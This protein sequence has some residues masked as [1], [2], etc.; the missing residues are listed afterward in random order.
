MRCGQDEEECAQRDEEE[1]EWG[2]AGVECC[3]CHDIIREKG[4]EGRVG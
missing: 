1:S 2:N 4:A 3:M